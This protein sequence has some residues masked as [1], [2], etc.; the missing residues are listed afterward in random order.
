MPKLWNGVPF[1]LRILLNRTFLSKIRFSLGLGFL[2]G[3]YIVFVT[4]DKLLM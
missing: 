1:K 4:V 2:C 3:F